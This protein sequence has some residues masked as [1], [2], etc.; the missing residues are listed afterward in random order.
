MTT[1]KPL[2]IANIEII[3]QMMQDFYAIDN[4]PIDVEKSKKLFQEFITNENL[5][6]SWLIFSE[7][8]IVGYIILTFIFSFE[9]GGKIAFIDELFIK[10]TA[11]G[12]GIGKEAIQFIQG[13]VPKL[14]LKLLYLEVETHNENA[15]KLYL[16][17]DFELHNRKLMKYKIVN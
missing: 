3:T 17:H 2:E 6:K 1:F 8:E 14:S 13:E 10:E 15:Q 16:A 7:N 5:G 4:Y 9:Y 12:K 11:R